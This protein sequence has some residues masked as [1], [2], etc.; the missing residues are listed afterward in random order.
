MSKRTKVITY[1]C[2]KGGVGKSTLSVNTAF[3]LSEVL[4][5]KKILLIDFDPQGTASKMMRIPVDIP[6]HGIDGVGGLLEDFVRTGGWYDADDIKKII[7]TPSY[8]VKKRVRH[9]NRFGYEDV[10][11]PY[12]FDI[13][14]TSMKLSFL[15]IALTRKQYPYIRNVDEIL[16]GV[17]DI[18]RHDFDYD[19]IIIDSMPSLGPL[20][21]NAIYTSDYLV[22]P[23]TMTY[24]SILGIEYVQELTKILSG[25]AK[26]DIGI[27]GIA[28]N[29]FHKT[30]LVDNFI[31]SML[32]DDYKEFHKFE[33]KI[34]EVT[35]IEKMILDEKIASHANDIIKEDF[36]S[37]AK[38]I[39]A[40]MET[41]ETTALNAEGR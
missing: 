7:Y 37:L 25:A 18:L 1:S 38:E 28:K 23:T 17:V 31:D 3:A 20:T 8:K 19:Y 33:T 13:M 40:R 9:G 5:D 41:L 2:L 26:R 35:S 29:K 32:E 6:A 22:I 15:E 39:L 21:V 27:L 24:N 36:I 34:P 11:I 12:K 4:T 16:K 14:P 30:A 10:E